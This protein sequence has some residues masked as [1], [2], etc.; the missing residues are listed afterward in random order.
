MDINYLG[1][2]SFRIKGKNASVVIDPYDNQ[3][4]PKFPKV[5]ADIVVSSHDHHDHSNIEAVKGYKKEISGP[6]EYEVMGVSF[7]GIASYH[8][9]KKGE[10]R[11]KNTI[12]VIEIDGIRICHLG[13]LG[14]KLLE[15]QLNAIGDID[16][17]MIPVGG[18]YTIDSK[19]AAEV[20]KQIEPYFIIPM[21]YQ[22]RDLDQKAFSKLEPVEN[23]LKESGTTVERTKKLSLKKD[24]II[25]DQPAK[26]I[27][28]EQ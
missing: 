16:V 3:T 25:Q 8:D 21:H 15:K 1:H 18:V 6:G 17:L 23:F 11:G 26:V 7:I 20:V 28:L 27:V 9:D 2:S 5:E 24:E 22:H 10:D 13:D 12:F 14:H 19:Q 4:G